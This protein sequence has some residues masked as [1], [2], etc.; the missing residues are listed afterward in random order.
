MWDGSDDGAQI[1]INPKG[2]IIRDTNEIVTL[3]ATVSI[4]GPGAEI[5]KN[6]SL[7]LE[8]GV[9]LTIPA[10][11]TD[12]L[13]FFGGTETDG[14]KLLGP[15]KVLAED[16]EFSGGDFGWQ[17]IGDSVRIDI[18]ASTTDTADLAVSSTLTTPPATVT[19]TLK[20]G[21]LGAAINVAAS[22]TL[23]IGAGITV[24][25]NG[26]NLRKAGQIALD[27]VAPDAGAI[28]LTDDTSKILTGANPVGAQ[29]TT[30]IKLTTNG[31]SASSGS[32]PYT[33][34]GIGVANLS[35]DS[36][37]YALAWTTV[38]F[39]TANNKLPVG[40]LFS[41]AGTSGNPGTATADTVKVVISSETVT[42]DI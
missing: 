14:A 21:G 32:G 26:T 38:S 33:F 28:S 1:E 16:V 2:L 35:G 34:D 8:R 31:A 7:T 30:G 42:D 25:L 13:R 15:G 39:D 40:R 20:A 17:A 29:N 37:G 24:D 23:E 6:Q 3:P 5:L 41:L 11:A 4:G 10:G 27:Y 36:T 9:I 18:G 22:K 19:A 12:T